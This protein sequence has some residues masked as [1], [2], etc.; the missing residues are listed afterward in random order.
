MYERSRKKRKADE[1]YLPDTVDT[2]ESDDDLDFAPRSAPPRRDFP[3]PPAEEVYSSDDENP[4]RYNNVGS[5]DIT[6]IQRAVVQ[7]VTGKKGTIFTLLPKKG[8]IPELDQFILRLDHG[9]IGTATPSYEPDE[10]R[11]PPGSVDADSL[12]V[13]S[14]DEYDT[15][16]GY[17][18]TAPA[19]PEILTAEQRDIH[20][21]TGEQP[22]S[23]EEYVIDP[24]YIRATAEQLMGEVWEELLREVSDSPDISPL[25]GDEE[26]REIHAAYL[27]EVED[28]IAGLL[29][30]D[31]AEDTWEPLG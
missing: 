3:Y 11:S 12:M 18:P 5:E 23:D 21:Q 2:G 28:Y 9:V 27:R 25:R 26:I 16:P 15:A 20:T 4:F 8:G 31:R 6:I 1:T 19:S 7:V 24:A 10:I 17:Y 30:E 29:S 22:Q 14:E 13:V